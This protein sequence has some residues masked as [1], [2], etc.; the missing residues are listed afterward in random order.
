MS[1]IATV[2]PEVSR[3]RYGRPLI[4]P[5]GGGKPVAYTR[6]TTFIDCL[7]D[8]YNLELWKIRQAAIGL[9]DRPDL[10]LAVTTHRDDKKRLDRICADAIEAAKS[11]A[12]ATTG[13]ALHTL[14]EHVDTGRDL[15]TLPPS[16]VADLDAYRRATAALTVEAIEQF[17]V[18]DD[19][20]V[21]GTFDRVVSWRGRRFVA[22]LKTGS[23]IDFSVGKIAMQLAVYSRG[24]SY[25]PATGARTPLDVDQRN[26]LV[27]HL[28]AG[29]ARCD[30]SFVDLTAGWEGVLLAQQVR[31]WRKRKGFTAPFP[32]E[33]SRQSA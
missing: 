18:C 16:A 22:D 20:A 32:Q 15:P 21:G 1:A 25:D 17:V 13:T 28:P 26:G 31:A 5:P 7:D 9:A 24:Q 11:S 8:R 6:C 30:V 29:Q 2:A 4:I 19:L 3:D 23:T 12:A 10:A 14:T 27:I 33:S